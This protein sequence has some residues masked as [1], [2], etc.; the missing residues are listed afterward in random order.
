MNYIQYVN[1][2]QG[3]R[4]EMR[5]SN[6][7]TLPLVQMPFGFAAFAPQTNSSRGSW[8][9]HPDDR[10]FEGVR[11]TRQPSPWIGD[12]GAFVF[13]PQIQSPVADAG[14]R[15]S[16]FD[17]TQ[18]VLTPCYMR[19]ALNRS[20][21][22]L[23][24]VPTVYGAR[25]NITFRK[26]YDRY[27]SVLPVAGFNSY[28]LDAEK[29]LLYCKTDGDTFGGP[30]AGRLTSYVVL[31]FCP[32]DIDGEGTLT[33]NQFG[34]QSHSNATEGVGAAIHIAL[35]AKSVSF[36]LSCSYISFEQALKN[37]ES[38]NIPEELEALKVRN[39]DL[40]NEYLGRIDIEADEETKRTFYSCMY[41]AFLYPHSA[42]EVGKNG[43]AIH[44]SPG[45]DRVEEGP[46]YTDN[47]FWDTYR[48]NYPFYALIAPEECRL[49][50]E[51]Y[52]ND[53][54]EYGWFPCW[55]AGTAKKCMPSTA[56]DAVITDCASK[57]L[58]S[59][60]LL[61]VAFAGMEKHANQRSD[62][63]VFGREGCSD[64]LALGYV[65][66]DQYKESVNLT[67]DA[68]YFDG[69]LADVA[70]MLGLNEKRNA[71]AAR[72]KRYRHLF[73]PE[74][75][76]MRPKNSSGNFKPDFSPVRW[77]GDY[78]EAAAAQ[79]TFAVQHDPDGL[80]ELYGGKSALLDA[81][82][83]LFD[84][85]K[86]FLV[87]GYGQEIHEMSEM[88]AADL[89][90]CAISNQPSFHIPFFYSYFGERERT[91]ARVRDICN[92]AFSYGD[93]GFPGDE[94]N[95]SMAIWYIFAC[96]GLFPFCPGK[97]YYTCHDPLAKRVFILEHEL[98][99]DT[100]VCKISHS[101]LLDLLRDR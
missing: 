35:K 46:R 40:W 10:S 69:C 94:D 88:A 5:F 68:A 71:Y 90:Q 65:P 48:T 34:V 67:L 52:I 6:G 73:D 100:D 92:K 99:I 20:F 84:S 33:E 66:C 36:T 17:P 3:T 89:G 86:D 79:T 28:R 98:K 12:H 27:I 93:D 75:K 80:A 42:C 54:K 45:L 24:L 51:G 77:G 62:N 31:S 7:N 57:G 9:F 39:E 49:F 55:T 19:Y 82:D 53:Y 101:E 60:E 18:T 44:Y 22:V 11:L 21:S 91:S 37:T 64:Y 2:K 23:E 76:H 26:D 63:P 58:L 41:R 8:Y 81:V 50:I 1:I 61:S 96:I 59:H 32:E 4:S 43:S 30:G 87:G 29:G 85:P 56:I 14:R 78:T 15:W 97:P 25:V 95:G 72:S 70:E 38:E 16:S 47:G 74:T 13:M 83:A